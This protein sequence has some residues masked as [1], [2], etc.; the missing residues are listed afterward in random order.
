MA[1]KDANKRGLGFA[2]MDSS[3]MDGAFGRVLASRA[4]LR[5]SAFLAVGVPIALIGRTL[6]TLDL[7]VVAAVAPLAMVVL[8]FSAVIGTGSYALIGSLL[9]RGKTKD[10]RATYSACFTLALAVSA[11]LFLLFFFLPASVSRFLASGAGY[12]DFWGSVD[13]IRALAF[14][15]PAV[16]LLSFF[17]PL[18]RLDG[19]FRVV[20]VSV[21]VAV[22]LCILGSALNSF[23][24]G[25]GLF[26]M[27]L[28]V[29]AGALISVF[30]LFLN[31]FG[32]ESVFGRPSL[33]VSFSHFRKTAIRVFRAG[34]AAGA[35]MCA[36]LVLVFALNRILYEWAGAYAV[37]VNT[38]VLTA[39]A[40]CY[41]PAFAAGD[42]VRLL[43][44]LLRTEEDR[45]GCVRLARKGLL[46]GE[47]LGVL[48]LAVFLPARLYLGLFF[49]PFGLAERVVFPLA[50]SGFRFFILTVVLHVPCRVLRN[51]CKGSGQTLAAVILDLFGC[52]VLPLGA[53][54]LFAPS[55]D[56]SRFWLCFALG[57]ALLLVAVVVYSCLKNKGEKG[58]GRVLLLPTGFG[59]DVLAV[60]EFSEEERDRGKVPGIA[61]AVS[62]FCMENGGSPRTAWILSLVT[63]ESVTNFMRHGFD[64]ERAHHSDVRISR[65]RDSWVF[66][67]CDDCPFF[68]PLKYLEKFDTGD[69]GENVGLKM[70]R[71]MSKDMLYDRLPGMNNKVIII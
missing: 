36:R 4:C 3:V 54:Y 15:A 42:A 30:V 57:D 9:G 50:V 33:K 56:P 45:A 69:I 67:L 63:E 37:A 40:V 39:G 55:S 58:L 5:F 29:A 61:D 51:L 13:L 59:S 12:R 27:G 11:L 8:A 68:S 52:L 28:S 44:N 48:C 23:V 20:A 19:A 62:E 21:A 71:S 49:S 16:I 35:G 32:S 18:A 60:Y 41:I 34:G 2:R 7:A 26:G 64:D 65:V 70:V 24:F 66:R 1:D 22:S 53:A 47:V 38:V 17:I 10:F 25:G 43:G 6:D 31:F 46:H 14:A